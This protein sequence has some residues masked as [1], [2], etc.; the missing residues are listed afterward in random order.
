M[1]RPYETTTYPTARPTTRRSAQRSKLSTPEHEIRSATQPRKFQQ[2][3]QNQDPDHESRLGITIR[4]A[5]RAG[6]RG[7]F[8]ITHTDLAGGCCGC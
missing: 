8:K 7:R 2:K 4:R 5:A 3:S 6:A 1:T